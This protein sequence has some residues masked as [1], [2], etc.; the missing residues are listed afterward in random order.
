LVPV[1]RA[2]EKS[3]SFSPGPIGVCD[4]GAEAL[5]RVII[6]SVNDYAAS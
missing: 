3:P 2:K 4:R 6:H 5:I 1:Q